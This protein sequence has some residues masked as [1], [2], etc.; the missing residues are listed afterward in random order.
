ML[1][2][3]PIGVEA[4][5]YGRALGHE[6]LLLEQGELAHAV[7]RW[8]HV[9]L[10]SP[11]ALNTSPLGRARLCAGLPADVTTAPTGHEL[12]DR[13]LAPLCR[14]PLLLGCL[15]EH[16]RVVEVGRRGLRKGDGAGDRARAP[17]RLLIE[18]RAGESVVEA[19]VVLDC[20]GTYGSPNAIG[21]GGIPAPGER[22]LVGRLWRHLPD[23]LGADR[24]RFVGRK[25]LVVGGGTSAAVAALGLSRLC[26]ETSQTQLTWAMRRDVEVPYPVVD[27]G[28]ES[29][30]LPERARLHRE[31]NQWT[32]AH[33]QGRGLPNTRFLPGAAVEEI[34]AEGHRLR[35]T[36]RVGPDGGREGPE[37]F[38]EVLGLTGYGPDNSLYRELQVHECYATQ[39]PM[40]VATALRGVTGD[41]LSQPTMTIAMLA[42]PEP[43]FF[44]LGAKSYGR[45][46][47][48]LLATG[49]AQIRAVFMSLGGA[50][51]YGPQP[52]A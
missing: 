3:G 18:G 52:G 24:G 43:N 30:P 11:W 19:D 31:A 40:G 1:G 51:L 8:G 35:V 46:A 38:D 15:R 23:V 44:L 21:D 7:R 6:V 45:S 2:A 29:D 39:A 41:C 28:G 12:V 42:N 17:F 13:Y 16:C 5:L 4:A 48:F 47:G 22:W 27:P 25:L 32:R 34:L 26:Q 9:R 50:D 37:L 33:R 20:T 49:H 36:L 14:D 10:F